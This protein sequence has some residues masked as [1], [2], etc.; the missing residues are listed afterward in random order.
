MAMSYKEYVKYTMPR[1]N[2]TPQ[3]K[4]KAIGEGWKR[5]KESDLK[6]VTNYALAKPKKTTRKNKR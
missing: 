1:L 4:M 3:E 5:R 2:G 6:E